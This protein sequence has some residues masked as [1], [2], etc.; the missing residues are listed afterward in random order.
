MRT[1]LTAGT[2]FVLAAL[3]TGHLTPGPHWRA[4]RADLHQ[5][6]PQAKVKAELGALFHSGKV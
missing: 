1:I 4:V 5:A 2:A 3:L 6:Q